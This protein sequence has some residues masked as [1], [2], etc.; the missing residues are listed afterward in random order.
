MIRNAILLVL[1]NA[2]ALYVATQALTGSFIVTGGIPGLAI[3][4]LIFGILNSIVKPI[5]KIVA[6]PV[7][8]LSAGLFIFVINGVILWL[9]KYTLWILAF[10]NIAIII[11]GGLIT[12]L[13]A[14]L[15]LGVIN[16]VMH[17]LV[18]A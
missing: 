3:A 14:V 11:K 15:I 10:E 9:A 5:L 17:W 2:L 4:G 8:F 16:I 7:V 6:L 13:Y 18:R 12:W 1:M